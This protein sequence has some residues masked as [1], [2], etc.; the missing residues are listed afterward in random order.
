MPLPRAS[1]DPPAIWSCDSA[2]EA[3]AVLFVVVT[4]D[5]NWSSKPAWAVIAREAMAAPDTIKAS[6]FS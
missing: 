1:F 4:A 2:E 6:C 3:V 5:I